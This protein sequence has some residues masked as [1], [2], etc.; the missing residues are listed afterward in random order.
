VSAGVPTTVSAQVSVCA[1]GA[2]PPIV[3]N[4]GNTLQVNTAPVVA[5]NETAKVV[6]GALSHA[7]HIASNSDEATPQS[8]SHSIS[9]VQRSSTCLNALPSSV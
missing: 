3:G 2:A 9:K 8:A 4:T 7:V 1:P 6:F 5:V